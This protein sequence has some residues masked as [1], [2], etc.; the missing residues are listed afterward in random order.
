V[1][2]YSVIM[3]NTDQHNLQ[4]CHVLLLVLTYVSPFFIG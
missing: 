2:S 3:L 1:L 4:V